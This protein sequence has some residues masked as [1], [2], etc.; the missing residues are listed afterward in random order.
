[1]AGF[2]PR[3]AKLLASV[4]P[5]VASALR[6]ALVGEQALASDAWDGP[7]VAVLNADRSVRTSTAAAAR[8]LG[9]LADLDSP[10]GSELP[11]VI[12]G[13]VEQLNASPHSDPGSARA[14]VRAPSGLWL[15]VHAAA[16]DDAS[17]SVAVILEPT[18]PVALAPIIIAAYG[19]TNRERDVTQRLLAGLARKTI[20]TE[21][22]ISAYT[23]DDHIKAVFDKTGV[24]SAGQLRA[25][26]FRQDS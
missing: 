5:L 19:L 8:W 16:L 2:D 13:V 14:R 10:H 20:A 11:T 12:L 22:Q 15:T 23:V 26:V 17:G 4:A 18:S 1:V 9:E 24:S 6:R 3:D 21:L 7:G 25:Q